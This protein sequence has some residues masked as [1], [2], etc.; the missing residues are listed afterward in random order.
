MADTT[1]GMQARLNVVLIERPLVH[2]IVQT[3]ECSTFKMSKVM[4]LAYSKIISYLQS[5]QIACHEAPFT[6]YQVDNWEKTISLKGFSLLWN[7]FTKTWKMEMGFEVPAAFC[8]THRQLSQ[9]HQKGLDCVEIPAGHYALTFH[10]GP[11]QKVGDAY[12]RIYSWA[13]EQGVQLG[14]KSYEY[15]LNDPK[16]VSP[17]NLETRILVPLA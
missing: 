8:E 7:L 10:M 12:K 6:S 15:Y 5:H 11:Y 1:S 4:G 13:Q 3:G 17:Q 16:K 2:A 14:S 9:S